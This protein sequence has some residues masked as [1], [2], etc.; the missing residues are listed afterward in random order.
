[1]CPSN[2]EGTLKRSASQL[3]TGSVLELP[4]TYGHQGQSTN[5]LPVLLFRLL[6]MADL[7][8]SFAA[9]QI[10]F[11]KQFCLKTPR[12]LPSAMGKLMALGI[13]M[14]PPQRI[15]YTKNNI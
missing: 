1:M 6:Q 8:W 5:L 13:E 7:N 2:I 9:W 3:T 10:L 15:S 11:C 12:L 14:S 4:T